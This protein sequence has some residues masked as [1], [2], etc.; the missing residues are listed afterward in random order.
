M[1]LSPTPFQINDEPNGSFGNSFLDH[2]FIHIKL[3][4]LVLIH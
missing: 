1:K 3:G 4:R 2:L